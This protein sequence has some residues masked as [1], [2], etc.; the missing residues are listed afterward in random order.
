M[1]DPDGQDHP[2][3]AGHPLPMAIVGFDDLP[4]AKRLDPPLTVVSQDPVAVG[5]TAANLLFAR[6]AGDR[7]APRKVVLLT[8]LV[9][10][11]SGERPGH[12]PDRPA[13]T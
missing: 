3:A 5:S 8:R 2:R 12:R 13:G 11:R 1:D 9:E 10:R 7:S 4:L 6:I